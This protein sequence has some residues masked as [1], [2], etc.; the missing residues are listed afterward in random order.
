MS[1]ETN[2]SNE[3]T[4]KNDIIIQMIV[5]AN[6]VDCYRDFNLH[7]HLRTFV[8]VIKTVHI[9]NKSRF[10]LKLDIFLN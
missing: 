3:E 8:F 10:R 6:D 5:H 9:L 4:N 2:V 1:K 7:S